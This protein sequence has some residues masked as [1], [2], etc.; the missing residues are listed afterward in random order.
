MAD[1]DPECLFCKIVVGDVP[2]T[3]V[4]EDEHALAFVDLNPQAPTH[5]L[6][7]PKR[8]F[9]D[10]AD[11][12]RDSAAAAGLLA[13]IRAFAEQE[14]LDSFRTVFNTGADAQQTVFHLHAHVLA[15]RSMSWPPG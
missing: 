10:I 7:I 5:V 3:R 15:G 9:T 1:A 14:G 6:V 12:G 2:S 8:H 4:Y 11:I 13:G